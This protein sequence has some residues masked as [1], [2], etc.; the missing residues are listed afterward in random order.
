MPDETFFCYEPIDHRKFT[1]TIKGNSPVLTVLPQ[2]HSRNVP[3]Y[4]EVHLGGLVKLNNLVKIQFTDKI[5]SRFVIYA[6]FYI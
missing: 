6:K 1:E 4:I 3:T 5:D 2:I